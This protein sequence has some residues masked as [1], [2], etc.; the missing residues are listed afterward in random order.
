MSSNLQDFNGIM[1][2]YWGLVELMVTFG[3]WKHVW[4]IDLRLFV[5]PFKIVYN[6]IL[7]IP[8]STNL[9]IMACL[10]HLKMKY[11]NL[12]DEP[13]TIYDDLVNPNFKLIILIECRTP[14]FAL[15]FSY[16]VQPMTGD[17]S[18]FIYMHNAF[19]LTKIIDSKLIND[20]MWSCLILGDCILIFHA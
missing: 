5:V 1:T 6:C 15:P 12:N 7:G 19:I 11:H 8:F 16:F 18:V 20:I 4:T 13:M 9:D 17:S 10:I 3:K 2:H 14:K